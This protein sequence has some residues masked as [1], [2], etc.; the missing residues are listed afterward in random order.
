MEVELGILNSDRY[1]IRVLYLIKAI[2][3]CQTGWHARIFADLLV[4]QCPGEL[5]QLLGV[6]MFAV[7]LYPFFAN[8]LCKLVDGLRVCLEPET[9][10]RAGALAN[11]VEPHGAR[12]A[13]EQLIEQFS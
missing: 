7:I 2:L 8:R 3:A 13:A 4:I 1:Q 6:E 9:I 11:R 10:K 12:I 5:K